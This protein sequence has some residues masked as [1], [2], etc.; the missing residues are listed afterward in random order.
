MT[1]NGYRWVLFDLGG[2]LVRLRAVGPMAQLVGSSSDAEFWSRWLAS[3]W[4]RAFERGRC[5]GKEFAAGIAAEWG[6]TASPDAFLAAFG[7]WPEGLYGGAEELVSDVR[8]AVP[9]GCLTNSNALHWS[10]FVSLWQIDRLFDI[11]FL[12]HEMGLVKPDRELFDHV[13]AR[14]AAPP[15]SI[16]FLDDNPANV[17]SAQDAGLTAV[18]ASGPHEARR[19]LEE[20]G[21]LAAQAQARK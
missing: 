1:G 21:V 11:R 6:V 16:V 9:V 14:L 12:S 8:A 5:T 17:A 4:V 3:R 10:R 18:L 7:S 13:V 19:V 15:E 2:V 20:L